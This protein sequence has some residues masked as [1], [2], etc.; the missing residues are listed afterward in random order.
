MDERGLAQRRRTRLEEYD[1][2]SAG[3]YFVTV[4]C[5]DRRGWFGGVADGAM[6]LGDAGRIVEE[7]WRWLEGRYPYVELGPYVVMPNHL[8]GLIAIRE[9]GGDSGDGDGGTTGN[10]C[11]ADD[12][13]TTG[14]GEAAD[15]GG[16]TGNGPVATGPYKVSKS[17]SGLV[18][19]FKTT[20]AKAIHGLGYAGFRWQRS[21]HD[22][23]V[24]N[25][26]E[27]RHI[28]EYIRDNPRRWTTDP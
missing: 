11:A 24:R 1:Y 23:I 28:A 21:F 19:A 18:G 10:G 5:L 25:D 26:R 4:C 16:T 17:L 14:E 8:H 22:R 7:R 15:D 6:V 3:W 2:R 12:G 9:E 13:G 20:S 27:L